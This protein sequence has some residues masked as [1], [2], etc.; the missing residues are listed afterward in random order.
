[1]ILKF[2]ETPSSIFISDAHV[3]IGDRGSTVI[4]LSEINS[5]L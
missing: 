3:F 5:E 1:M 2:S 4:Q